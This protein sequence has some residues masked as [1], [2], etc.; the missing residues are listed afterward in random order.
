MN[1]N[2][3][4][5]NTNVLPEFKNPMVFYPL[6]G[7]IIILIIILFMILFKVNIPFKQS[8]K[9]QEEM[10][11]DIFIVLFS[12][13]ITVLCLNEFQVF[14]Y[15]KLSRE[16]SLFTFISFNTFCAMLCIYILISVYVCLRRTKLS[17]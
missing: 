16:D 8:P 12:V 15:R 13:V 17:F 11:A 7:M 2:N 1:T 6:I 5:N 3:T 14:F 10:V 9:S 4:N